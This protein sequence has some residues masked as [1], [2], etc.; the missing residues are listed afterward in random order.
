MSPFKGSVCGCKS[1]NETTQFLLVLVFRWIFH[2]WEH[3]QYR[4]S[5]LSLAWLKVAALKRPL[6]VF[7]KVQVKQKTSWMKF[8]CLWELESEEGNRKAS[9]ELERL[10]LLFDDKRS[11]QSH[12]LLCAETQKQPKTQIRRDKPNVLVTCDSFVSFIKGLKFVFFLY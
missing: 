3:S 7:F 5:G 12:R 1:G 10:S 2:N 8:L 6:N 9:S 4:Q 11:S